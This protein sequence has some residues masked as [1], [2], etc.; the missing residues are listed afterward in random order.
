MI[1]KIDFEFKNGESLIIPIEFN[2]RVF[3]YFPF[4][5]D[6]WNYSKI[7]SESNIELLGA[8]CESLIMYG[9]L[10]G[11]L[12]YEMLANNP[13]IGEHALDRLIDLELLKSNPETQDVFHPKAEEVIYKACKKSL[14]NKINVK[15]IKTPAEY[16]KEYGN[17][18]EMSK[19]LSESKEQIM[20]GTLAKLNNYSTS[21]NAR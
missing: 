3:T 8:Y 15:K 12:N 2:P 6:W 16:L 4:D 13:Y 18:A 14:Q 1:V 20:G 9:K 10:E 17:K 19:Y 21:V 7:R 11:K 5:V